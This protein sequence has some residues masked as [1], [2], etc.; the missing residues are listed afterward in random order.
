M[1]PG[2][3]H[4]GTVVEVLSGDWEGAEVG[5]HNVNPVMFSVVDVV[6]GPG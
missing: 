1:P 2:S 6:T 5:L 3:A 4:P